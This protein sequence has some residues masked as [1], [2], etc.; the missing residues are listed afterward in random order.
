MSF[1]TSM[2]FLWGAL[3]SK[4]LENTP[5]LELDCDWNLSSSYDCSVGKRGDVIK[6]MGLLY[7]PTLQEWAMHQVA[8]CTLVRYLEAKYRDI[9]SWRHVSNAQFIDWYSVKAVDI[10]QI[11]DVK[12]CQNW[13]RPKHLR[14]CRGLKAVCWQLLHGKTLDTIWSYYHI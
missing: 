7:L 12:T 4:Q 1:F 11:S 13:R 8:R 14:T 9:R 5:T 6:E 3:V 10:S 2:A